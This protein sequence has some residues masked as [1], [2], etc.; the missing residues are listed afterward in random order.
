MIWIA[1]FINEYFFNTTN[2]LE[3]DHL[4]E[5][6]QEQLSREQMVQLQVAFICLLYVFLQ[7]RR[8]DFIPVS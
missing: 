1:E 3:I 6:V 8:N 5:E 7:K 4:F 2:S